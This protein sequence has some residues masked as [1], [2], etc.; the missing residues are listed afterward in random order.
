M[1]SL[2]SHHDA[3]PQ[4]A[5]I[6]HDL[7][8]AGLLGGTLFGRFALHPAVGGIRDKAERGKVVNAAW[9]RY[10]TINALSLAAVTAGWVSARGTEARPGA[11]SGREETLARAKDGLLLAVA[12]S[13]IATA[14]TGIRFSRS[15]PGGAVPLE[16][17]DTP[18]YE[19]TR[20]GARLKR[21]LNRLGAITTASE[22][23]FVA[24]NAALAQEG[25]SRP[26]A[27][28]ALRRRAR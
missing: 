2:P 9:R 22:V 25:H 21:R 10:G 26:P 3:V 17:G 12:V 28:R 24:V 7:G 4:L 8:A 18:A 16:D 23:G 15:A 27:R 11:L 6:G 20:E 1:R 14:V 19:T 13:G 5:R